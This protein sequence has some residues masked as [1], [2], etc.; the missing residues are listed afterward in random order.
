M[1]SYY[2]HKNFPEKKIYLFK[3]YNG[4][5]ILTYEDFIY[6]DINITKLQN[7]QKIKLIYL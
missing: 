2:H 7:R 6:N 4:K 3:D 5:K 1:T